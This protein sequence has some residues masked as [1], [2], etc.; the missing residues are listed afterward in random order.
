MGDLL[1]LLLVLALL[2]LFVGVLTVLVR[3]LE[4]QKRLAGA[5]GLEDDA[6]PPSDSATF[7]VREG[8]LSP[9][10]RAF[11]PVLREAVQLLAKSRQLPPPLVLA[12]VRIAEVLEIA[13]KQS[14]NRSLWQT[15]HN[16]ITRKQFDFVL[17]DPDT[18]RPLL[19]VELNDRSHER[20]DRKE[21][22]EFVNQACASAGLPIL[23]VPA[24][25]RYDSQTLARDIGNL[26]SARAG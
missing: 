16:K 17:C 24:A 8:V 12:S 4:R 2:F 20:A 18:T 7:R 25:G 19:A 23:H 1:W 9:G 6:G 13:T 15:V 26:L 22:D 10:E 21:R 14:E 5:D 3:K 11:L